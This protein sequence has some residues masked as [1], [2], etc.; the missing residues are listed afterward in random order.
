[1]SKGYH[2][3]GSLSH[4]SNELGYLTWK[5]YPFECLPQSFQ[6][7]KL[8]ELKLRES[9]I[10]RLWSDTKVL[11]N[12]KRLD[13]SYSKKLVEMPE[14]TEALNLEVIDL[15]RCIQLRKLS[16]S[17]GLLGKLTILNLKY[18]KNLVSLPNSMLDL[19]SLEY[20]SVSRCSNLFKN[21]L[22]GQAR[23]NEHLKKLCLVKGRINSHST[24]PSM[25]KMLLWTLDLLYSKAQRE[26]VNCLLSSSPT[27]SC[28]RELDLGFCN[29][30]K[31]PDVIGNLRCLEKLNLKGNNFVTLP[32]LKDLFRLY[33]LNLQHCRL[34]KNFESFTDRII[35]DDEHM[36]GLIIFNCP[37]IVEMERCTNMSVSWMLQI[38]QAK[39]LTSNLF[40][41]S[42]ESIIPGSEIPM[43][44]NNQLVSIDNSI[45]IDAS[46][47]M[48][49]NNW[50]G[51]VCC[52]IFNAGVS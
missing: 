50:V 18:C 11:L 3:S 47:V 9:S 23:N 42:V 38:V 22:L 25:K 46:P 2:F 13:L 10:E 21:E 16:P 34:P 4:L 44:F 6:S 27:L 30:V 45:I 48:H 15:E 24:S 36:A 39:C 7:H 32:N 17:I 51:V 26:S 29:L 5:N 12:L 33:Y 37:E 28:L 19:N 40:R 35:E 1:M 49:D 52:A 20:L 14:V 43:W 41:P 31:S 8:V